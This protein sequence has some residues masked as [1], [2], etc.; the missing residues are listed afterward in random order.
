M[1]AFMNIFNTVGTDPRAWIVLA[2]FAARALWSLVELA[3]CPVVAGRAD[4]ASMTPTRQMK[5]RFPVLMIL[6]IT[7]SIVGLFKISLGA[8][9]PALALFLLLLGV[10]LFITEPVRRQIAVAEQRVADAAG[11]PGEAVAAT[12]LRES[13]IR[14]VS[15]EFAI[16]IL[17]LVGML[18]L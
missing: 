15:M 8:P 13:H 17:L 10:Y 18:A 3:R 6:G 14:L 2:L 16:V 4:A 7:L 12:D 9:Q 1:S 5:G 11:G